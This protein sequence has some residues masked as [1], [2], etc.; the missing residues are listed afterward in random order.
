MSIL[1]DRRNDGSVAFFLDGDLQFDSR[2]EHIYHECLAL[3]ALAIAEK[4]KDGEIS[5][6]ILG[7]GDGLSAREL[8]KSKRVSKIDLVD[9]DNEILELAKGEFSQFNNNSLNDSRMTIHVED[10]HE[11]IERAIAAEIKYDVIISDFTAPQTVQGAQLHSIEFYKKIGALLA[12]N[13]LLAANTVSPT[14]TPEAYWS[15]FNSMLIS[16][17]NPRPYR[18]YLPSFAAQG[19]G[20]DWGFMLASP[21]NINADEINNDLVFAE[22][23][24]ELTDVNYLRKL[25]LFAEEDLQLQAN[26]RPTAGTSEILVHYLFNPKAREVKASVVK[27]V[28][29]IDLATL[30]VPEP[31]LNSYVLPQELRDILSNSECDIERKEEF[32]ESVLKMVPAMQRYQTRQMIESFLEGPVRFLRSIDLKQLVEKLLQRA[33]ELPQKLVSELT[34]LK[35]ELME[36]AGDYDR[37]LNMGMQALTVI[38]LVVVIGNLMYPDAVYAKGEHAAAERSGGH[39]GD[40]RGSGRRGGRRDGYGYNNNWGGG[41]TYWNGTEYVYPDKKIKVL[42]GETIIQEPGKTIIEKNNR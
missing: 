25:F 15:I 16:E 19:Y 32:I 6:L 27:D 24:K 41:G 8:L 21:E 39:T 40:H 42:P 30:T 17:L 38:C 34:R 14:G 9:Y 33:S 23:R 29:A 35:E 28:L 10:A 2:D 4:R 7:G 31:I 5:C 11:F 26:A 18:I 36:F 12:T 22:P 3:P 20:S 1:C 13:G 37:L